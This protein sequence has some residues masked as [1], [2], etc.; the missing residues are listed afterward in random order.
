MYS[1]IQ[2]VL[3]SEFENEL[4]EAVAQWNKPFPAA[5]RYSNELSKKATMEKDHRGGLERVR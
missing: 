5:E 3:Y 2:G 4:F 1:D